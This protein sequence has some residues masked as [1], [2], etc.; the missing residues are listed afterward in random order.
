[1]NPPHPCLSSPFKLLRRYSN[2]LKHEILSA[3]SCQKHCFMTHLI[4]LFRFQSHSSPSRRSTRK[5]RPERVLLCCA[6]P[7]AIRNQTFFGRRTI[8]RWNTQTASTL[9]RT[10]KPWILTTSKSRT[11]QF[12]IVSPK[13]FSARQRHPPKSK[14]LTPTVH[15]F[16]FSNLMTWKLYPAQQLSCLVAPKATRL[17][18]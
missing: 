1:M 17:R 7:K 2:F 11:P 5:S 16:S 10:I 3:Y 15:R 13:T 8:T 18:W 12:T 14:W 9:P 6:M 4:L